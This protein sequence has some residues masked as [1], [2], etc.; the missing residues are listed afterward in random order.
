MRPKAQDRDP[1]TVEALPL[2]WSVSNNAQLAAGGYIGLGERPELLTLK[3]EFGTLPAVFF[4]QVRTY[5]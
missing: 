2:P 3:S 4:L 5:F 1:A